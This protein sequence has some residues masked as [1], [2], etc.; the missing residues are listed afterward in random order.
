M[1]D[2]LCL[3]G[4]DYLAIVGGHIGGLLRLD[5]EANHHRATLADDFA[6]FSAHGA[7][8]ER[9]TALADMADARLDD[10]LV[11]IENGLDKVGV[12]IGDNG[13]H[14]GVFVVYLQDFLKVFLFAEVVVGEVSVVVNMAELVNVVKAYLNGEAVVIYR[15]VYFYHGDKGNKINREVLPRVRRRRAARGQGVFPVCLRLYDKVL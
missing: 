6:R 8:A 1:S 11:T 9:K 13:S 15:V 2:R 14:F 4:V 3:K 5:V 12:D 7:L 10:D